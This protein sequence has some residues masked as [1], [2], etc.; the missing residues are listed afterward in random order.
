MH[1][2]IRNLCTHFNFEIIAELCYV[3]CHKVLRH[4]EAV[5]VSSPRIRGTILGYLHVMQAYLRSKGMTMSNPHGVSIMSIILVYHDRR[6]GSQQ[7]LGFEG[8]TSFNELLATHPRLI[9]NFLINIV[10][11]CM[12]SIKIKLNDPMIANEDRAFP[13]IL[14]RICNDICSTAEIIPLLS[15]YSVPTPETI[16]KIKVEYPLLES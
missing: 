10:K 15:A 3:I 6:D 14:T 2:D 8:L 9:F 7:P 12:S 11:I 1:F 13:E 5:I 16:V 4:Y